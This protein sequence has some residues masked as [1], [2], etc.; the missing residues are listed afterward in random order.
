MEIKELVKK[1]HE[2]AK[3]KGFWEDYDGLEELENSKKYMG[4]VNAAIGNRLM[5][6]VSEL[7]E[8]LEALRKE[9]Y[10]NFKE[11]IADVVIRVGDLCGGLYIDLEEEIKNKMDKNVLRPYKHGKTF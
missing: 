10:E 7:G 3:N 11:E 5:L 2:N 4:L 8:A 1:A 6:I 9:D